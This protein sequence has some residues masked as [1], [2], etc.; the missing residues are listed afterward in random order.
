MF[1]RESP[2][3]FC[4]AGNCRAPAE[5]AAAVAWGAFDHLDAAVHARRPPV[6][7]WSAMARSACCCSGVRLASRASRLFTSSRLMPSCWPK[8]AASG[9]GPA[10]AVPRTASRDAAIRRAGQR[11]GGQPVHQA[12]VSSEEASC[13]TV[14]SHCLVCLRHRRRPHLEIACMTAPLYKINIWRHSCLDY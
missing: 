8:T 11:V 2:S 4:N 9:V 1:Q 14:M 10:P 12:R 3:L 5:S 6:I 13:H 7:A